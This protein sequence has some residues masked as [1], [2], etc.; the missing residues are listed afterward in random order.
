MIVA[1][2]LSKG[3]GCCA[4]LCLLLA[5]ATCRY[6]GAQPCRSCAAA[7]TKSRQRAT[8]CGV[9]HQVALVTLK[10]VVDVSVLNKVL[11]LCA[12]AW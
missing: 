4:L 1:S 9:S 12:D 6:R 10:K 5:A 7:C 3:V 2:T 11:L 8:L